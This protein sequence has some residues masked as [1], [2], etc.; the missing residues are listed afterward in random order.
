MVRLTKPQQQALAKAYRRSDATVIAMSYL[1]FRRKVQATV[2]MDS[3]VVV[4]W[5]GMWLV[6]ETDGYTH[7]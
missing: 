5:C 7:S 6:I 3:A 2:C 4:P 1:A